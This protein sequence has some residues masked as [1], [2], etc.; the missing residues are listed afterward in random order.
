MIQDQNA[1]VPW[2]RAFLERAAAG[3]DR[4]VGK[5]RRKYL[6]K[7]PTSVYF[8]AL[9]ATLIISL[10]WHGFSSPIMSVMCTLILLAVADYCV[11]ALMG[12]YALK[13]H[14]M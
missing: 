3:G 14:R 2:W 11:G 8:V 5:F 1:T 10:Y 12:Q 13:I 4:A 7:P 9:V 6:S